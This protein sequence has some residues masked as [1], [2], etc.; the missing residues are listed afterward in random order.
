MLD[1]GNH[2]TTSRKE[3]HVAH[4]KD[5]KRKQFELILAEDVH[6]P[7]FILGP[8]DP[9]LK[10]IGQKEWSNGPMELVFQ[11]SEVSNKY[12]DQIKYKEGWWVTN[13]W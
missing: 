2:L 1:T 5:N 10:K 4:L 13:A 11:F 6:V 9:T 12:H 7:D 8:R 3:Y